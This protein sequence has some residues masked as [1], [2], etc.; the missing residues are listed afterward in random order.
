[1]AGS[2]NPSILPPNIKKVPR[3]HWEVDAK[4]KSLLNGWALELYSP[5]TCSCPRYPRQREPDAEKTF[6]PRPN[7]MLGKRQPAEAFQNHFA[8]D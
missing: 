1:M 6:I 4:T 7:G 3:N 8:A 5:S 2:L